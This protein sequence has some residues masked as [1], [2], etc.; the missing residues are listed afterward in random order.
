MG[1]IDEIGSV[2]AER[3]SRVPQRL[4]RKIWG[5]PRSIYGLVVLVLSRK[6][7]SKRQQKPF[8]PSPDKQPHEG[9]DLA[10]V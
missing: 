1:G 4:L 5:Y 8:P 10:Q 7:K 6:P 9:L 3:S 2:F